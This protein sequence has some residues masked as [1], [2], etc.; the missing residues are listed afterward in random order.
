MNPYANSLEHLRDEIRRLDVLLRRALV[1]MRQVAASSEAHELQGLVISESDIESILR[2]Q[3]FWGAWWQGQEAKAAELASLDQQ[4]QRLRREIDDRRALSDEAEIHLSLPYVARSLNLSQAEVD[5]LLITLAPE[6][7]P[8]YE[9]LYGYLQNDVTRKRPSVNLAL[10]LLCRNEQEKL[11]A[12]R[13]LEGASP[14]MQY[15][16]VH[17]HDESQDRHPSL[18]RRFLKLDLSIVGFL[19]DHPPSFEGLWIPPGQPV[20]LSEVDVATQES[21]TNLA[22]HCREQHFPGV[23]VWLTGTSPSSLREAA[24]VFCAALG[25]NLLRTEMTRF[26][27]TEGDSATIMRDAILWN[28]VLGITVPDQEGEKES[29]GGEAEKAEAA[30]WKSLRDFKAPVILLGS[31][32]ALRH[33]PPDLMLWRRNI[34]PPG[35]YQRH[36]LWQR[37]LPDRDDSGELGRLA[38]TFHFG[39]DRIRQAITLAIGSAAAT[40]PENPTPSTQELLAA[41]RAL[42]SPHVGRF[43][44]QIE[45]RYGWSDIVLPTD[46]LAQLQSVAVW[47]KY[48]RVVHA[49]WGFGEKLSRGKG[50]NVLFTGPSG[51][52]KTMAA[53]V[54]AG[55]LCLD[56]FQIDLSSVVSKYI[57]ETEKNLS[58]IFEKAE[59]TQSLLFFDEADALFG[60][61][62][63][64]KDAHDRY[65]NIEVNYLLQRVEQYEGVVILA[66]N[67]Q[68]NLDDAFVRRM[69]DIIE[70]PFPDEFSR[71]RIWRTHFPE[72]APQSEDI[73]FAFLAKQFKLAGGHIKNIVLQAA[74]LAAREEP[75][76]ITMEHL[77][78]A[79]NAEFQKQ[80]KMSIKSDF[81]R[82]YEL[83]RKEVAR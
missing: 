20:S 7:D 24:E 58:E 17:L 57:G 65:A 79:T 41:G 59:M 33:I 16:L 43:A 9:T 80:G 13:L 55:E 72:H 40:H 14:L 45:P 83:L 50:L 75:S 23:I 77:I 47:M 6:L 28:A 1:I 31:N 60:K 25:R 62:T 64:V 30:L 37:A 71:E 38:D 11:N 36:Q 4:L 18:L 46:K 27:A 73:D 12:R 56:L 53:E 44:V 15:G 82:Y 22:A 49:E 48:R 42:T 68:R 63:E 32:L 52:G 21:L 74:F 2:A 26:V 78:Q 29:H 67:L 34:P 81:G 10:N 70:F 69:Q 51:T 3:E 76:V 35:Y 54:L 39:A 61:R 8:L 66:T 19:L 5:L